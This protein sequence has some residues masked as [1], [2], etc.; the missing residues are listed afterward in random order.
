MEELEAPPTYTETFSQNFQL[1]YANLQFT[2]FQEIEM[3]PSPYSETMFMKM[4]FSLANRI[5]QRLNE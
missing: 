4:K 3:Y 5:L 2:I 1:I